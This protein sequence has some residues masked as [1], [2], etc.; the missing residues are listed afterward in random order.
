MPA[1]SPPRRGHLIA[2][3]IF[4]ASWSTPSDLIFSR[5]WLCCGGRRRRL[6]PAEL[7][8]LG[9]ISI[10]VPVTIFDDGN[11]LAPTPR[12]PPF[13]GMLIFTPGALLRNGRGN[14]PADWNETTAPDGRLSGEGYYNL[15]RPDSCR[16]SDT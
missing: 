2:K 9:D 14:T 5:R 15:Y 7:S 13:S 3:T 10:A 16:F 6:E 11:H 8:L 4:S 1:R 12:V